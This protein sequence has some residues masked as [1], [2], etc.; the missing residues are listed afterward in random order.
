MDSALQLDLISF[1]KFF[2]F[3]THFSVSTLTFFKVTGEAGSTF[4]PHW[5]VNPTIGSCLAE[6]GSQLTL[7][8]GSVIAS[9]LAF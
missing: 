2:S 1:V 9:V 3:Y 6:N 7:L 5:P 8:L 4:A